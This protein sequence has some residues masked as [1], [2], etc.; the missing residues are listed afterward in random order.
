MTEEAEQK[1]TAGVEHAEVLP[2]SWN[3]GVPK[4]LV[5]DSNSALL[6]AVAGLGHHMYR[7]VVQTF[8]RSGKKKRDAEDEDQLQQ[9]QEPQIHGHSL[10]KANSK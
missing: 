7:L 5:A 8:C 6:F 4:G 3:A 9:N 1:P 2:G 10:T